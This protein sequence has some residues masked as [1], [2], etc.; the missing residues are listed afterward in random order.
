MPLG[1]LCRRCG[2]LVIFSMLFVVPLEGIHLECRLCGVVG[3]GVCHTC[4]FYA[5]AKGVY[6]FFESA[7]RGFPLCVRELLLL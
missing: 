2:V 1:L 4:L 5:L 7:L 3:G 6:D